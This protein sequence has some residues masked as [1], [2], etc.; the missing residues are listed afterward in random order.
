[1]FIITCT[2]QTV[3]RIKRTLD[4]LLQ[5]VYNKFNEILPLGTKL[6]FKAFFL[7]VFIHVCM[8]LPL[9]L[10]LVD[11]SPSHLQDNHKDFGIQ[12]A[13]DP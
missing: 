6:G 13:L 2:K 4:M 8:E 5:K 10:A 9:N 1:M 7:Q 12:I 3:K 11:H